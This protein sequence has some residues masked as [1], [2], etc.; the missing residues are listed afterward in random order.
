MFPKSTI[1]LSISVS[2]TAQVSQLLYAWRYEKLRGQV[3][4]Y[5][6]AYANAFVNAAGEV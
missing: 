2:T 3:F 1:K 5:F 6:L 4:I